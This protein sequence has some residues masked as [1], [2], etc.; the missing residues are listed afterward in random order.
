[1]FKCNT[2]YLY[3]GQGI[4][5]QQQPLHL[6]QLCKLTE[7]PY[8]L[9]VWLLAVCLLLSLQEWEKLLEEIVLAMLTIAMEFFVRLMDALR[10]LHKITDLFEIL[11]VLKTT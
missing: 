10:L 4:P 9:G 5:G 8:R 1:M 6:V 3:L 2:K 11:P 7:L